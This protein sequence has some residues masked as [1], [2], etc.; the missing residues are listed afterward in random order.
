MLLVPFL[1]AALR[2]LQGYAKTNLGFKTDFSGETDG[3]W[4]ASWHVWETWLQSSDAGNLPV[5]PVRALIFV[6]FILFLAQIV[7]EMIKSGFVVIR[8][9]DL[10]DLT[11]VEA[12]TRIE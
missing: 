3:R 5:G 2:L 9:E 8:R 6:G 1:W 7:S 4:P 12:P 10:A 11:V